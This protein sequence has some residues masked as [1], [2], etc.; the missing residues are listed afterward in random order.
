MGAALFLC[1]FISLFS[2]PNNT[3]S[4][5][6]DHNHG[7][8]SV[9]N[10]HAMDVLQE[11]L[12]RDPAIMQRMLNIEE[13]TQAFI[14][15]GGEQAV[16]AVVTIPVV[17]H[18]LYR[19]SSENIS[20]AQI[21]SQIDVLNKD[22][23]RTN[24]DATSKWSQAADSEI[25]FCLATVDPNGNATTG[26]TRTQTT[27]TSF[28]TNDAMKYSSQGGTN[29]WATDKYLNIWV[30]NLGGGI[31]GYAQFPG[32]GSSATDGV[33]IGYNYFGTSGTASYPFNKGRTATHEV[34]HWLNLRH[35]WGDGGCSVDDYVTDTPSSDAPNY[36]CATGHVSCSTA[37][38]V[39]NYMDYSDDACMNLFTAGQKA[40]MQALF[41]TGG[42]RR[43]L[44][45]SNGC[46]GSSGGGSTP[47]Y[48]S[49]NS[50]NTSYEW[51]SKVVL[52]TINN[53]TT[54]S[55]GG[56]GNYTAISTNLAKSSAYTIQL[57]P[58]FSG[59]TY[60]EYFKVYI[61][62]NADGDFDDA[63]ENV[64]SSAGTTTTVSGSFTV[65]ATATTGAT[66]MRI[67]MKDGSISSAC[68]AYTYGEVEDYTINITTGAAVCNQ[69]GSLSYSGISTNA[70]TLSWAA[71]SGAS[72]YTLQVKPS[73]SST[74]TSY[75]TSG[76]SYNL[77]TL[78]AS[79]T[80]N[81][82]VRTNCSSG[83]SN[84]TTGSNFTT[85]APAGCSDAY[86][87]NN[88]ISAAKTIS[89]NTNITALIGT[90]TDKDYFKFSN[91]S[92]AKNI[93]VTLTNLPADYDLRLYNSSG[94]L[95]YT[96]QNG[97]TTSESIVY[98]NAPVGTYYI[99]VYGYNG[100]YSA[101]SCYTLN[102][103][104]SSSS[105][106]EEGEI[107]LVPKEELTEIA[108]VEDFNV[109]LFPNPAREFLNVQVATKANSIRGQIY[110][111]TGR[112]LWVGDL[113]NG[114]NIIHVNDLPTGVYHLTALQ[115]DGKMITLKFVKTN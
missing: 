113:D 59:S 4:A 62:Y 2:Y 114:D 67:V 30:C 107:N 19:T 6:H 39:E 25:E 41:A 66:R 103:S 36:G 82:Q 93:R 14:R 26:V 47:Q 94:T 112:V 60:T 9:R 106:R 18:V 48:C 33:V 73:T 109:N 12:Q 57:T 110:D 1:L 70:A 98:N 55:T 38:M 13:H 97:G 115:G 50:T 84:Y 88:S 87:S 40:R 77:T 52:N 32:G 92:S 15:E 68:G 20:T 71:V 17:V 69:P 63:G 49:S 64:Y 45:T 53:T 85:S 61:D 51:I 42:A 44:L 28:T 108:E 43:S 29:A 100:V 34:G 24:S 56:Y 96:S 65:P 81:W 5:Q 16:R 95:L 83:S 79:T 54:A 99:Y 105:F 58:S 72:N 111:V 23:R 31:L 74:W 35:I 46:G 104:R 8:P 11:N 78:S 37:D 10:C 75:T 90:S 3:V 101:S 91:T 86:E 89:V 22:F 80:Y 76:T 21:Q 102:A 27:V 7:V